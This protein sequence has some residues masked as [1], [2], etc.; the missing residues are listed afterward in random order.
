[1]VSFNRI[2][3]YNIDRVIK[4]R[5]MAMDVVKSKNILIGKPPRKIPPGEY[6]CKWEDG[7]KFN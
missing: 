4:S 3:K 1:M 7:I 2:Q 5:E 6:E